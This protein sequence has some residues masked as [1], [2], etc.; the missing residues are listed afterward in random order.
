MIDFLRHR[1]QPQIPLG[2]YGPRFLRQT[3]N[4]PLNDLRSHIHIIGT[5][6][7]GKSR[8][9]A[10]LI[11]SLLERGRALTLIDPHGD[12]V[13]LVMAQLI[14]RGFFQDDA[15][16]E[17]LL[18]LDLPTAERQDRFLPFNVL[19]QSLPPHSLASN[20][21]EAF[22]RAW[23]ALSD[24]R[25]PMF[26][27]LVQDSVKVLISNGLPLTRLYRLLS[28][29]SFR[30]QLLQK[31]QDPDIVHFFR[32]QFERLPPR[33]QLTQAGSALRR[34]HLLTFSPVLRHSLG[35]MA[36][37]LHFRQLM[38]AGRSVLINLALPDAD[39]RRLLGCLLTVFAEQGAL[40]RGDLPAQQRTPLHHLIID[41][42][43]E[44][45]A[46]SDV[47]L[48]RILSLTRKVGLFAVLAHQTWSQTGQR[49]QGA[50]QNV[51]LDVTFRLGR[52]DAEFAARH[53]GAVDSRAIKHRVTDP[54]AA[55]R[56]HPLYE[57]LTEQWEHWV[58]A[59]QGL[60]DRHAFL[61]QQHGPLKRFQSLSVDDPAGIERQ[62]AEVERNYLRR[63][64]RPLGQAS[65]A[66]DAATGRLGRRRQ[67]E[68][69][70]RV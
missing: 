53:F 64:F 35:Q 27:T 43:S 19:D 3:V 51:G 23:P 50:L 44:F 37:Q 28:D 67:L 16:Y 52:Q 49:M 5:T 22:H 29:S 70:K 4:L 24:G 62:L 40:S 41:E 12:L 34:A 33:D 69:R 32:D 63:Y 20:V 60:P 21:K 54:I 56:G 13:R 17:R 2:S 57:P 7:S 6:G 65:I 61:R 45:A 42:W 18:Y 68:E 36:N 39:S 15:A 11:L 59:L 38:D 47:A 48:A 26:D 25:A 30:H 58:Q 14:A 9:L 1:R 46:Q 31:E 10:N 8:F 55:E 66:T